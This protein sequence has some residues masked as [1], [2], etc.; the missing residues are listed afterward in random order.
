MGVL[1]DDLAEIRRNN[2]NEAKC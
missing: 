2:T 1:S